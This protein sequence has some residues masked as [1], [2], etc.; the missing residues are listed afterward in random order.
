MSIPTPS[1]RRRSTARAT[2]RKDPRLVEQRIAELT[3]QQEAILAKEGQRYTYR[4]PYYG[5]SFSDVFFATET[6]FRAYV[7]HR[8]TKFRY[9]FGDTLIEGKCHQISRA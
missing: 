4:S 9:S 7:E 2:V 5:C 8:E 1:K 6:D 3:A